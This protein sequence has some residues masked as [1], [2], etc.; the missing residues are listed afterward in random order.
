MVPDVRHEVVD[1]VE[2]RVVGPVQVLEHQ[3][4]RLALEVL[5]QSAHREQQVD[6]FVRRLV[7]AQT[8]QQRE[9]PSD[10]GRVGFGEEGSG[11][12]GEL[13]ARLPHRLRLE[14]PGRS[15]DDLRGGAR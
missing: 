7:H 10:L 11:E 9:V 13:A 12:N 8:Q 5:D 1:Q 4:E 15:P 6:R 2:Q 14:D 3:Q